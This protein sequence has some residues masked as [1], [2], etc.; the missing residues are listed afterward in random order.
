MER[1]DQLGLA[2]RGFDPPCPSGGWIAARLIRMDPENGPAKLNLKLDSLTVATDTTWMQAAGNPPASADETPDVSER[3]QA[4][5]DTSGHGPVPPAGSPLTIK[6]SPADTLRHR[7]MIEKEFTIPGIP[8]FGSLRL[9]ADPSGRLFMNGKSAA[10]GRTFDLADVS[11]L[12]LAG[13]NRVRL[14]FAEADSFSAAGRLQVK[15]IA[16]KTP[17]EAIR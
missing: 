13:Q 3:V 7:R 8:V 9:E 1:V 10:E 17:I 12:V 15:Y 2:D 14:E 16:G 11:D 4:R 6:S 5:R